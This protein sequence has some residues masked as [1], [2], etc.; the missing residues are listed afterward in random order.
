MSPN[1]N[2]RTASSTERCRIAILSF[3]GNMPELVPLTRFGGKPE[4]MIGNG[5]IPPSAQ[6][7]AS[8]PSAKPECGKRRNHARPSSRPCSRDVRLESP[9]DG[10]IRPLAA[11]SA[12]PPSKSNVFI[13]GSVGKLESA[14]QSRERIRNFKK[15]SVVYPLNSDVFEILSTCQTRRCRVFRQP[16]SIS[17]R[18]NRKAFR[19]ALP[20]L[21]R[22][23]GMLQIALDWVR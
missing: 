11:T 6:L 3:E 20:G 4:G 13:Q 12:Q 1:S 14:S 15:V 9:L 2:D 23:S 10:G 5:Q 17:L 19:S 18:P 22:I 8:A 21:S 7:R 16:H